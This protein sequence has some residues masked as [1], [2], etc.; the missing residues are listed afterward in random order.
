MRFDA[1]GK[2]MAY[3]IASLLMLASTRADAQSGAN[4]LLVV[5]DAS[6]T[7][8]TIATLYAVRRSVP[9]SNICHIS[10]TVEETIERQ[11]YGLQI[12]SPIWRCIASQRAQDR[13]LYIVLTKGVPIRIAGTGG[14]SGTVSSVDSEL[15]LLYRRHV[16]QLAAIV[17]FVPNPYFARTAPVS[18]VAPFTHDKYDIYLVT[19]LDGYTLED[20]IG[21]IDRGAAPVRDGRFILDERASWSANGNTWLH[22]AADRLTADGF[23]D[24]VLLDESAKVITEQSPVLGYYSWGSNDPA[25]RIRHFQFEFVPGALAAMFVSS[26]ARTFK[27][28]PPEW[29]PG[30]NNSPSGPFGGSRQSLVADFVHDGV[31]GSAGHVAEPYLDSAI[32]PDILFPAY[33]KGLNLAEAFYAAMPHLSWQTIVLG[34]PLCAPFRAHALTE[35]DIDSGFDAATEMPA[36]FSKRFL[37]LLEGPKPEARVAYARATVR[38]ERGDLAGAR[39]ALRATIAA[40]PQFTVARLQLASLHDGA[41][42]YDE[43][44]AQYRAVLA[45]APNQVIALNNLAYD[46][47]VYK[48]AAEE[49]LPLAERAAAIHGNVQNLE[50]VL[51]LVERAATRNVNI[52]VSTVLDTVA[53]IQH[54]L[55]RPA[56]AARTMRA[57]ISGS[58]PEEPEIFWHAAVIFSDAS[59]R[60]RATL[61]LQNALR[62]NSSLLQRP[63]VRELQQHLSRWP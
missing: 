18:T 27:Q 44:I 9:A 4:V 50:D 48:G 33:L 46:L 24:R 42:G 51:R 45:Y 36:L 62:L 14:R 32:R 39:E 38:E 49:A 29:M 20:V 63:E 56:D 35:H 16:G 59:D 60:A 57:A 30:D 28:P 47:A 61:M 2:T 7:G 41:R 13:I 34:D 26:D 3:I 11:T 25:I 1:P 6:A 53:W 37:T 21:L 19:R 31:T 22:Q 10:T 54:L 58:P 40:E 12:E 55:G 17:G 43:A 15:T 52:N 5:N 23:G 8:E